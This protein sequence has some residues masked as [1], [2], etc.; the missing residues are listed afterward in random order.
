MIGSALLS[1]SLQV[2]RS[3]P[4]DPAAVD[5]WNQPLHDADAVVTTVAGQIQPLTL[6]EVT[7]LSDAGA[8]AGDY[9]AFT[10][11]ADIRAS[12]RIRRVD[13]DETF[14]IRSVID[15]AGV[16]HHLELL[17]RRVVD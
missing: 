5:D 11:P 16:G 6:E 10:P 12:D 2:L 7:A 4:Q 9:R 17:L 15:A 8:T 14:E 13:T 1:Q 3:A